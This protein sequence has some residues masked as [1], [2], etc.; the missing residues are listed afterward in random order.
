MCNC[1]KTKA[2]GEHKSSIGNS[3]P[4]FLSFIES[5]RKKSESP[6]PSLTEFKLKTIEPS[7]EELT[8]GTFA[9]KC[10]TFSHM[11]GIEQTV[12]EKVLMAALENPRYAKKL[13]ANRN[14]PNIHDLISNPPEFRAG[15]YSDFSNGTLLAKAGKAILN[16]GLSGFATVSNETLKKREDACLSC[17]N[18]DAAKRVLQRISASS[19]VSDKIGERTG[20]KTCSICGCVVKNKMRLATDTCPE[21]TISGLNRWGEKISTNK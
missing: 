18:L 4:A 11:L 2:N 8:E 19:R 1:G 16:W 9:D 7:F 6:F 3:S 10:R 15:N 20:N 5:K 13:F 12:P 17:P 14:N 21:E